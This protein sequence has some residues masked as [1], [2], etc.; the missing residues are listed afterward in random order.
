MA[1]PAILL[2]RFSADQAIKVFEHLDP[3]DLLECDLMA[4]FYDPWEAVARRLA[5]LSLLFEAHIVSVLR[6]T[7]VKVPFAVICL[8]QT[9]YEG[10]ATAEFL[11]CNH[12]H[13]KRELAQTVLMAREVLPEIADKHHLNRIE[14]RSWSRHPSAHLLGQ[15]LGFKRDAVIGGFGGANPIQTEIWSWTRPEHQLPHIQET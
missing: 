4:G 15:A 1:R 12:K 10:V 5:G 7:G 9:G 13:F 2:N 8:G 14:F 6:E 3:Q 11:S